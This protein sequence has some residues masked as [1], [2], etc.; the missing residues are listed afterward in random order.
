MRQPKFRVGEKVR[1]TEKAPEYIR[2]EWD[3]REREVTA[4]RY[5][6]ELGTYLYELEGNTLPYLFRGEQLKKAKKGGTR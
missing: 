6:P 4:T 2:A 5:D 1:L 3:G